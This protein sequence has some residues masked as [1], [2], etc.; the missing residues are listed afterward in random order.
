MHGND[1]LGALADFFTILIESN[2]RGQ[3]VS[4]VEVSVH[5]FQDPVLAAAAPIEVQHSLPDDILD[6][7][8]VQGV[9]FLDG[10]NFFPFRCCCL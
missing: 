2:P 7:G 10:G 5:H 4:E 3:R 9:D 6:D 1:C 8:D